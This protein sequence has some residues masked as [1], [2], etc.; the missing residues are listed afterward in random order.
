MTE[1]RALT[2]QQQ[3]VAHL[4]AEYATNK[5]IAA[6]LGISERRV[7]VHISDIVDR[8]HLDRS[9]NLRT[10]ILATYAQLFGFPKLGA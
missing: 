9:R 5:Q 3:R 6:A 4:V 1:T 2:T 8:W 10:Q 7:E